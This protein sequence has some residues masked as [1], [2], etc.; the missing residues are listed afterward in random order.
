MRHRVCQHRSYRPV[1]SRGGLPPVTWETEGGG[2]DAEW[3]E[4]ASFTQ[5][6]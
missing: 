3:S 1:D 4:V 5:F 2:V 6:Y